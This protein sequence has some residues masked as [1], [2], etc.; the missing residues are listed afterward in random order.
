[1]NKGCKFPI[2]KRNLEQQDKCSCQ[3]SI[4]SHNTSITNSGRDSTKQQ[5]CV[6]IEECDNNESFMVKKNVCLSETCI[7]YSTYVECPSH[8]PLGMHCGNQR[9]TNCE[10]KNLL[11][12]K[13]QHKGFGVKA[14]CQILK[15]DLIV[16]YTGLAVSEKATNTDSHHYLMN[17]YGSVLLN[18]EVFGSVARYINHSCE[19][20]AT[21][22]NWKVN[23]VNRMCVVAKRII[24]EFEEITYDYNWTTGSADRRQKCYCSAKICRGYIHHYH[25]SQR[26][27][28][29][30]DFVTFINEGNNET[31]I[32][33][34]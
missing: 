25:D 33:D 18:A 26:P 2:N 17:W 7:N 6:K 1:M 20:N 21:I 10:W 27:R 5:Q 28:Q 16:E 13:D 24:N 31:C 22:Q 23:G 11:V 30:C 34:Q 12:F 14:L 32:I 9:I 4:Q 29:I 8:C 15:D 3:S 19:P